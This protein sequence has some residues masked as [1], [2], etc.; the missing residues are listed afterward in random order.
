MEKSR[1]KAENAGSALDNALASLPRAEDV[2]PE[3]T[4]TADFSHLSDN[5]KKLLLILVDISEIMDQLFWL[6]SSVSKKEFL[7]QVKDDN[8]RKLYVVR[9]LK[10]PDL[11]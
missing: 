7:S 10:I 5:Q 9:N 1:I 8:V 2:Y 6:Q 3:F 4:L 11:L